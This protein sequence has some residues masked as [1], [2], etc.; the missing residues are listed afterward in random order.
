MPYSGAAK[1]IML[2]AIAKG[3]SPPSFGEWVGLLA[4]ATP[5]S[6]WKSSSTSELELTSHG[7]STG[8]LIVFTALTGGTGLF[9]ER[10]YYVEEVS[11][12]KIKL[13]QLT[14]TYTEA[15]TTEVLA[16]TI[17][18]L[19]EVSGGSYARIKTTFGSAAS[20]KTEDSTAHKISVPAS[21]TVSYVGLWSAV[22]T[23]TLIAI[24][25][26]TAETFAAEGTF[27]VTASKLDLLGVA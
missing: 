10:P 26:V 7:L 12:S 11:S 5:K 14:G 6:A 8:N 24:E 9:V 15:W 23:G 19:T 17:A 21:T 3:T 4:E 13:G 27:E 16:A 2:N 18:K 20:G 25:K 1:N 22:T